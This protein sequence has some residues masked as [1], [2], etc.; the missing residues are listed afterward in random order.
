MK[1]AAKKKRPG[2]TV[3]VQLDRELESTFPASDP[4]KITRA[5][6]VKRVAKKKRRRSK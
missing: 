2:R 5:R 4:L 6:P 1:K 3:D